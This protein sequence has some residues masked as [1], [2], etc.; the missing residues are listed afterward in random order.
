MSTVDSRHKAILILGMHRSGTSALTRVVNLLGAD[1][2]N[3]LLPAAADN[4]AG[5]WEHRGIVAIHDELLQ[6][7]DRS[8]NDL[9]AMPRGWLQS[10]AAQTAREK[11]V[12]L[13]NQEFADTPL[14]VVKDPRLCRLLPLWTNV[15]DDLGVDAHAVLVLRHPDEVAASLQA[16]N[17]M[18]IEYTRLSWIEH[19]AEAELASRGFSRSVL[20]Y[21][22]LLLD[23]STCMSR[24]SEEMAVAW[25]VSLE[26]A[27][28]EID[29]FVNAGERHHTLT[30]DAPPLPQAAQQVYDALLS[31]ANRQDSDWQRIEVATNNYLANAEI[32]LDGMNAV[33]ASLSDANMQIGH[34]NIEIANLV[35]RLDGLFRAIEE[36]DSRTYLHHGLTSSGLLKDIA[37]IYFRR[38]NE[39]YTEARSVTVHHDG[40]RQCTALRFELP[41]GALA[42][43]IRFDPSEFPGE[44]L[45]N[46]L[47]VGGVFISDFD[48]SLSGNGSHIVSSL[49]GQL[50]IASVDADP[51]IELDISTFDLP[52]EGVVAVELSC[53][54]I[55]PYSE[56]RHLIDSALL[57]QRTE[58]A[59]AI[60]VLCEQQQHTNSHVEDLT[61]KLQTLTALCIDSFVQVRNAEAVRASAQEKTVLEIDAKIQAMQLNQQRADGHL[62]SLSASVGTLVRVCE[63]NFVQLREAEARRALDTDE[64]KRGLAS[65]LASQKRSFFNRLARKK[66]PVP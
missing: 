43:F 15:I 28:V 39:D 4:L 52:T 36:N 7:L 55:T 59:N 41:Q 18:A 22:N 56:L 60:V 35:S 24:L 17:G 63:E 2:G 62:E 23:W 31:K 1:V 26:S 49:S 37:K 13:L 10:R 19:M 51:N 61:E 57:T 65:L 66:F 16:R 34:K 38:A 6:S 46:S 8:W 12:A 54:R 50:R 21:D 53:C 27:S 20:S 45:I 33:S 44:F 25:P 58:V 32:F 11:L 64:L 14:W 47:H 3:D 40:M 30:A 9:R 42:D 29:L 48:S 5:F